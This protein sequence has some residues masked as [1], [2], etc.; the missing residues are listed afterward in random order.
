MISY[1]RVRPKG[2]LRIHG[3]LPEVSSKKSLLK[4][5]LSKKECFEQESTS[6]IV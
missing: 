4:F 6:Q 3:N 1:K 5:G 2:K